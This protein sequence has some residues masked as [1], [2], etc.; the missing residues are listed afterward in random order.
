MKI[1]IVGNSNCV[2]KF[3][4]SKAFIDTFN[5]GNDS[6]VNLSAGGSCCLYHIYTFMQ[7]KET[8]ESADL[9]ILDSTIIDIFHRNKNLLTNSSATEYIH[10]MY[11]LYSSLPAK[12]ISIIFPTKKYIKSRGNN[13]IY[14]EHLRLCSHFNIDCVDIYQEL[15]SLLDPEPYFMKESHL[16][17][18]FSYKIGSILSQCFASNPKIFKSHPQSFIDDYKYV[19]IDSSNNIFKGSEKLTIQS[20]FKEEKVAILCMPISLEKAEKLMLMG[21]YQWNKDSETLLRLQIDD[22]KAITKN[23]R[24]GYALF[25]VIPDFPLIKKDSLLKAEIRDNENHGSSS[26]DQSLQYPQIIGILMRQEGKMKYKISN[27]QANSVDL[28]KEINGKVFV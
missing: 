26:R 28:N 23:L 11:C 16:G 15:D 3:G 12:I 7:H 10:D 22:K 13:H 20:S 21:V 14:K 24:G 1:V 17:V 8:L 19:V 9:I 25:D 6:V 4:I 27:S 18:Q 5:G 2:F